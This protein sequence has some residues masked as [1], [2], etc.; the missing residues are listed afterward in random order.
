M[1]AAEPGVLPFGVLAGGGVD[2]VLAG[3]AVEFAG[4]QLADLAETDGFLEAGRDVA[5]RGDF[6]NRAAME[7]EPGA[8]GDAFVELRARA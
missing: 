4:E 5:E 6:F 2:P 3:G 7:H 1:F 8:A